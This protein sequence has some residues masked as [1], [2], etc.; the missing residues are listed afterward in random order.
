MLRRLIIGLIVGTVTFCASYVS[1]RL[2]NH[3]ADRIVEWMYP[4]PKPPIVS[5]TNRGS[6]VLNSQNLD[7]R[8]S[9]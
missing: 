9:P 8:K 4:T 5:Y 6:I 3:Y 1:Y 2:V 7:P